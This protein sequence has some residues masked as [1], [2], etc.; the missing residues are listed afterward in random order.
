MRVGGTRQMARQPVKAKPAPDVA[1]KPKRPPI[2]MPM[3]A[4]WTSDV[5][6][7]AVNV[8]ILLAI[9][10]V[11]PV[12][13]TQFWRSQVVIEPI[14]VP[15]AMVATGLTPEVAAGRLWDGLEAV[16]D[17][18]GTAKRSVVSIPESA[19]VDFA[20]PDSGLSID[21]L[22]YYVRQFFNSYETR[23]T[24]EFRCADAG[25][26]PEGQSLRLRV[27]SN[28]VELIDLPPRG[29]KSEARYFREA[30]AEVRRGS[31]RSPPWRLSRSPT[32]PAARCWRGG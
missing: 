30:A 27:V 2:T 1:P 24:G 13:V 28:T 7:L 32:R 21:S 26:A 25:C 22:V 14:T 15:D 3:A 23:V 8:T 18:A 9:L 12:I 20:I 5:R 6:T 29:A 10:L 31:I 4:A 19:K 11:V 17:E 16:T